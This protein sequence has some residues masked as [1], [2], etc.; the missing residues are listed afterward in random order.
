MFFLDETIELNESKIIDIIQEF[1]T[2]ERPKI[3]RRKNYFLGKQ[4]ILKKTASNQFK[5]NNRIVSNFCS[6]R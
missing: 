2:I 5:P 1:N 4:D 3:Q 6:D